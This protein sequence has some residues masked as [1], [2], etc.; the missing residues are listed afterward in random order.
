MFRF[1]STLLGGSSFQNENSVKT[2]GG[3]QR[4][5]IRGAKRQDNVYRSMGS[6]TGFL[7]FVAEQRQQG[8]T[9]NLDHLETDAG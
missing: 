9:C 3:I 7:L 5:K 4:I 2:K 6:S 8:N 1:G